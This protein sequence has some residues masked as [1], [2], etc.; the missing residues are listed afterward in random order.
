MK[1]SI[2]PQSRASRVSPKENPATNRVPQAGQT[3]EAAVK[4]QNPQAIPSGRA[5]SGIEA[6]GLHPADL[7]QQIAVLLLLRPAGDDIVPEQG[8]L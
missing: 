8:C 2:S 5:H 6:D 1:N 3:R 4:R 7:S